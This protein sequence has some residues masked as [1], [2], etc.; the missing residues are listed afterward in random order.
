MHRNPS[1]TDLT[2]AAAAA[3]AQAG[4]PMRAPLSGSPA[5]QPG[6]PRE[7]GS[8]L[9]NPGELRPQAP[10]APRE[11]RLRGAVHVC[12][13]VACKLPAADWYKAAKQQREMPRGAA[14]RAGGRGAGWLPGASQGRGL[15]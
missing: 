1:S 3:A 7:R 5:A 14:E 9:R 4:V 13:R 10:A 8:R 6:P 12:E 2:A 11:A 15:E